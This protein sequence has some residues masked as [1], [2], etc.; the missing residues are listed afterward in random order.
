M[1]DIQRHGVACS[2]AM[3]TRIDGQYVER[4]A[5]FVSSKYR[6]ECRMLHGQ[7]SELEANLLN[8]ERTE[9]QAEHQTQ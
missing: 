7:H 1:Y 8:A 4:K 9:R 5:C 2:I 6:R 3:R